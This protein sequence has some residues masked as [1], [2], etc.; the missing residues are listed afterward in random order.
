MGWAPWKSAQV[1]L[2]WGNPDIHT[3]LEARFSDC[4]TGTDTVGSTAIENEGSAHSRVSCGLSEDISDYNGLHEKGVCGP[5]LERSISHGPGSNVVE[6][7]QFTD[8]IFANCIM[9]VDTEGECMLDVSGSAVR[10]RMAVEEMDSMV[11]AS[12]A[13]VQ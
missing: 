1:G 4:M 2:A 10:C 6:R 13:T 12:T 7:G 11:E 3:A 5:E 8:V 9:T